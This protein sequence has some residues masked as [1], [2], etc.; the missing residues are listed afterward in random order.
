M[1][2]VD[3]NVSNVIFKNGWNVNL[4]YTNKQK[5]NKIKAK[6]QLTSGKVPLEK[7]IKRQVLPQA[8]SPTMTNFLRISDDL[9]KRKTFNHCCH[10]KREN[11]FTLF[12]NIILKSIFYFIICYF[13]FLLIS[14]EKSLS[15]IF[16]F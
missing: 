11:Q 9:K 16:N 2:T 3:L 6:F 15:L 12:N 5:E 13:L 14:K 4:T 7:T 1:F 10:Y 8:P